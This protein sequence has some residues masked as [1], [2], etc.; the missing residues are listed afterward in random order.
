MTAFEGPVKF[1]T[2][3]TDGA[4]NTIALCVKYFQTQDLSN[5]TVIQNIQ[6]DYTQANAAPKS[7]FRPDR[8]DIYGRRRPTFADAGWEDALPVTTM[9]NGS[10][11]TMS[12]EPGLTFQLRPRPEEADMRIVQTPFS[13]GLPVAMFDGSVRTIRYGVAESVFWA[14]ITP[15]GGEVSTLD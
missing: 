15:R 5:P 7:I 6:L 3:I 2:Q 14:A 13:A 1:P 9:V 4:S 8:R 12:S 11:V 10:A